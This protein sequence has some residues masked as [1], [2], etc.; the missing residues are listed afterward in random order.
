METVP[1]SITIPEDL[2]QHDRSSQQGTS[3]PAP[4]VLGLHPVVEH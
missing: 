3:L 2:A 4:S 1:F